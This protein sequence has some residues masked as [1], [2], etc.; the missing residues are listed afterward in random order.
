MFPESGRFCWN[1]P[2]KFT[3]VLAKL[4]R[5]DARKTCL[6]P[7]ASSIYSKPSVGTSLW[8]PIV[9]HYVSAAK[10]G[11]AKEPAHP[12]AFCVLNVWAKK[13]IASGKLALRWAKG[14]WFGGISRPSNF[15]VPG[16]HRNSEGPWSQKWDFTSLCTYSWAWH[17]LQSKLANQLGDCNS[18]LWT[19]IELCFNEG[20]FSCK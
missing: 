2:E 14:L 10:F 16:V 18:I 7:A 15:E 8:S 17:S 1:S 6:H 19:L 5:V 11:N 12:E 4:P 3:G 13:E 9:S 20:A